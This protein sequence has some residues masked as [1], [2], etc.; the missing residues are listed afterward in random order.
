MFIYSHSIVATN[1]FVEV[2]LTD[3]IKIVRDIYYRDSPSP[4]PCIIHRTFYGRDSIP[5]RRAAKYF[6]SNG[7]DFLNCC[8]RGSGNSEETSSLT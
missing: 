6:S 8:V 2:K 4:Y 1:R 3:R 5:C 7:F